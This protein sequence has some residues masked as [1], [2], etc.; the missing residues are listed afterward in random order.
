[1]TIDPAQLPADVRTKYDEMV[2]AYETLERARRELERHVSAES[3]VERKAP[4]SNCRAKTSH[5][6]LQVERRTFDETFEL[7][8]CAGCGRVS[9]AHSY[10]VSSGSG[11]EWLEERWT[12]YYPSPKSRPQPWWLGE[13]RLSGPLINIDYGLRGLL[14]EI[15]EAVSGGQPRLALMGVRAL[16]EQLMV[17]KVGDQGSFASNLKAFCDKGFI[18][19]V[20]YDAV[21][22]VLDAGHA[23]MHR[24]YKPTEDDLNTVLD[25]V[26]GVFAAIFVHMPSAKALSDQIPRRPSGRVIPW[27]DLDSRR[28]PA[29]KSG[30]S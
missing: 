29:G 13:L 5:N 26:E 24:M 3:E 2:A 12:D 6:V 23:T 27:K 7:I 25:I 17:V 11:G 9:F 10:L 28:P 30:D 1:M 16:L 8:E 15:Y 14:A 22:A 19:Q 18:S 4:C 20:Q 21:S